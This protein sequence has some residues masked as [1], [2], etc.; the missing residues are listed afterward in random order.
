M[1]FFSGICQFSGLVASC[2]M[3]LGMFQCALQM[4]GSKAYDFVDSN[5]MVENTTINSEYFTKV[6]FYYLRRNFAVLEKLICKNYGIQLRY[7]DTIEEFP[8]ILILRSIRFL[9]N[10]SREV[11]G[12]RKTKI[13]EFPVPE[14]H[15]LRSILLPQNTDW[16]LSC[17][18]KTQIW[19]YLV[20]E[21]FKLRNLRFLPIY[22]FANILIV[23]ACPSHRRPTGGGLCQSQPLS[24]THRHYFS[25]ISL[26][27]SLHLFVFGSC[28]KQ[29][30]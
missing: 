20:P 9:Q 30:T 25:G 26:Y 15:R 11:S 4:F 7:E 8:A 29:P 28:S 18:R 12:S 13:D 22:G 14:K 24:C 1:S 17:S 16:G 3:T 23:W 6:V 10:S 2:D 27:C 5:Y 19:E 21:N